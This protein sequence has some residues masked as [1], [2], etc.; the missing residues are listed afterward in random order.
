MS[1]NMGKIEHTLSELLNMCVNTEKTFKREGGMGPLLFLRRVQLLLLSPVIRVKANSMSARRRNGTLNS[2]PRE[3]L[4]RNRKKKKR[5]KD[6]V[7][8]V[9]KTNTRKGIVGLA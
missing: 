3:A 1:Y 5:P 4:R 2:N 8:I 7:S 6:S 9:G